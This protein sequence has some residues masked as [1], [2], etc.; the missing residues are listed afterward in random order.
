[1]CSGGFRHELKAIDALILGAGLVWPLPLLKTPLP[2]DEAY[3]R[4]TRLLQFQLAH[5]RQE[6]LR[7]SA[8]PVLLN[9][10]IGRNTGH[11]NNRAQGD[12]ARGPFRKPEQS[13]I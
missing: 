3:L 9:P 1:M 4:R 7:L 12:N 5:V 2:Y 8:K 6:S 13:H 11:E 10:E